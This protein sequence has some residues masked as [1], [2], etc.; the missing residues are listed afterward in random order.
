MKISLLKN[1]QINVKKWN[2]ALSKCVNFSI[3]AYTWYLDTVCDNWAAIVSDDYSVLMPLPYSGKPNIHVYQP[4]MIPKLGIFYSDNVKQV[5]LNFF[6]NYILLNIKKININFNKFIE[7]NNNDNFKKIEMYSIDL[8]RSYKETCNKYS[9]ELKN[10]LLE[11]KYKNYYIISGISINE[12]IAFLNTTNYFDNAKKYDIFRRIL[13][14]TII[15]NLSNI[16]AI[17]SERNELLGLGVF[18]FSPQSADLL[19]LSAELDDTNLKKLIVNKFIKLNSGK[20][21]TL[22]FELPQDKEAN[23]FYESFGAS[24]YYYNQL[25]FRKTNRFFK[26]FQKK[27]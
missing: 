6:I 9:A 23:E 21:L 13:S 27:R 11:K 22:N 1:N 5:E 19:V 18:V 3:Y 26:L 2:S 12:V 15:R 14:I 20:N 25:I 4:F 10:L 16:Y 24:K 8:Y 7:L 17:Y